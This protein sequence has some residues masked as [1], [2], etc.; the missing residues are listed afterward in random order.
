M[1]RLTTAPA[2][3]LAALRQG[4]V[5]AFPT[6]TVYGLGARAD[7]EDAIRQVF[8]LKGR[9]P[10]HPLIIHLPHAGDMATWASQV[11]ALATEL[12]ARFLPGPLTLVLPRR[13]EQARIAAGGRPTVALRVPAHPVARQLL[14]GLHQALVAPSANRFGRP[15]PTQAQHVMTDFAATDLLVLDGGDTEHGIES[16]ILDLCDPARPILLRPGAIAATTLAAV[17]GPLH[18]PIG[19]GGAPGTLASHYAPRQSVV[20]L[21]STSFATVGEAKPAGTVAALGFHRPAWVAGNL[22]R[23]LGPS[24]ADAARQLFAHL[25]DL[26]QTAA[27]LI[28]AELPPTTPAWEAITDR[29]VRASQPRRQPLRAAVP[30]VSQ[31]HCQ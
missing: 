15:S 25:R 19:T 6:E 27:S 29:L 20:L 30:D 31:P 10:D 24:P 16:T 22:W 14:A 9:P 26:E 3:A 17:T 8:A 4:R 12:A 23:A 1:S 28:A 7:D 18:R 21:D 2:T 11:P 13:P 5:V